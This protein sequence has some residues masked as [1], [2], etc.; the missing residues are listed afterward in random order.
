[1][2]KSHTARDRSGEMLMTARHQRRGHQRQAAIQRL[3]GGCDVTLFRA[4]WR[5]IGN[6]FSALSVKFSKVGC[7]KRVS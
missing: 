3:S 4:I 1:M 6:A 2:M 5:E 7:A